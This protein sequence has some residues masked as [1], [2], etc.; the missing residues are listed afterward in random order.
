MN[1]K[2]KYVLTHPC[3]CDLWFGCSA[4]ICTET[5]PWASA[6]RTLATRHCSPKS[7]LR[8]P[9]SSCMLCECVHVCGEGRTEEGARHQTF[10]LQLVSSGGARGEGFTLTLLCWGSVSYF[11]P[12][13]AF[14]FVR[15][16]RL[17]EGHRIKNDKSGLSQVFCVCVFPPILLLA[18]H[19]RTRARSRKHNSRGA[20][21]FGLFNLFPFFQRPASTG[22]V[23]P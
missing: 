5:L 10:I 8:H 16:R 3:F 4:T 1:R 21:L 18:P 14:F 13:S 20:L 22:D 23:Q 11:S 9:T 2:E 7:S 19:T 12:L 17:D 6:S 15:T